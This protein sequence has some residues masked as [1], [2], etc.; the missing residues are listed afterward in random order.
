MS[1]NKNREE[2]RQSLDSLL[3]DNFPDE[4]QGDENLDDIV[5]PRN[6]LT[7]YANVKAASVNRAKKTMN[8]LLQ[9]YLSQEVIDQNEYIQA[10][11]KIDTASLGTLMYQMETTE[12]AITTLLQAIDSGEMAPRMFEVLGNLQKTLLDIVKSQTMYLLATEESMKKLSREL[13]MNSP[14][15]SS[16]SQPNSS[17]IKSRGT[18]ELMRAIRTIEEESVEDVE[19]VQALPED[20]DNFDTGLGEEEFE[21]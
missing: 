17:G 3:G 8:A 21:D 5:Q 10:K 19:E 2:F 7:K 16:P 9:F 14:T 20:P 6:T 15:P 13:D 4:I 12:K 18:K 1:D 11:S